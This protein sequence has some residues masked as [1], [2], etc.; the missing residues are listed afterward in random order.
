[1]RIKSAKEL[2]T[3]V[4]QPVQ[5]YRF[6]RTHMEYYRG[7]SIRDYQLINGLFRDEFEIEHAKEI[8]KCLYNS[9]LYCVKKGEINSIREP[10]KAEEENYELKNLWYL[11]YQAQHLGLK[12]R[13]L[14]WSI[15]WET[16][17]LFAVE[18]EKYHGVDGSFWIFFCPEENQINSPN[19]KDLM[20]ISPTDI[21][22]SYMINSPIY[23][24]DDVFDILGERRMGRQSGRFWVQS[25]ENSKIPLNK[26]PYFQ[27]FLREIIID[28]DSKASIK[29]ELAESGITLDWH[30][31]RKDET[32]LEVINQINTKCTS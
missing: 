3:T 23:M 27:Q 19:I 25:I 7:H 20:K 9:F 13:L 10:F 14:D 24:L 22:E 21:Q 16:S 8:E 2:Y 30:N 17:L 5:N 26:Q 18:N 11:L 31:Y 28:G 32:I 4:I 12:T 15:G 29:K 6:G 1:M